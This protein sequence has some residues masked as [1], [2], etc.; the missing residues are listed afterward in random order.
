MKFVGRTIELQNRAV[1]ELEP[2]QVVGL[3]IDGH[4]KDIAEERNGF[5]QAITS[6][7]DKIHLQHRHGLLLY[8]A[9]SGA[10]RCRLLMKLQNAKRSTIR[11]TSVA[12]PKSPARF[13]VKR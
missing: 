5:I 2:Y 8:P 11:I 13:S 7:P 4:A 3:P 1:G 10:A 6:D 12:L 9:F